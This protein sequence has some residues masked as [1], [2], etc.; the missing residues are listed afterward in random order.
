MNIWIYICECVASINV[1]LSDA[2]Q[3]IKL[4]NLCIIFLHFCREKGGVELYY[5]VTKFY[6]GSVG[7]KSDS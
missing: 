6:G 3:Q 7:E 4:E 1:D 2:L 5:R